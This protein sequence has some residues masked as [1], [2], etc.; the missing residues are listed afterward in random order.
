MK[1]FRSS[2]GGFQ[3]IWQGDRWRMGAVNLS[4]RATCCVVQYEYLRCLLEAQSRQSWRHRNLKVRAENR[5]SNANARATQALLHRAMV[6]LGYQRAASSPA[7]PSLRIAVV[8]QRIFFTCTFRCSARGA[9]P[10]RYICGC[11]CSPSGQSVL[12]Y[13]RQ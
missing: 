2:G 3:T 5:H 12:R 10:N 11:P 7:W 1:K 4:R 8:G 6:Q 9:L 13:R